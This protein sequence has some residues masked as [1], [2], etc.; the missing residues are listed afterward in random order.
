[1]EQQIVQIRPEVVFFSHVDTSTGILVTDEYIKR[2]SKAG[3][4]V[5]AIVVLDW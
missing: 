2:V 5:G 3:H 1:M 4:K